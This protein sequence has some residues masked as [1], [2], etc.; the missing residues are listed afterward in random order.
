MTAQLLAELS[1]LA[2]G[3]TGSYLARVACVGSQHRE[4]ECSQR[5]HIGIIYRERRDSA[6]LTM[7]MIGRNDYSIREDGQQIGR[8][9][10]ASEQTPGVWLWHVQVNIP[11]PPIGSATTLDNAKQQF[12][13][14]W[15]AFK[16]KHGPERLA[17]AYA[18]MNLRHPNGRQ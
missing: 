6:M 15:L 8:I 18:A 1:Y 17:K 4:L 10:F 12:K 9:R 11:A 16:E 2:A 3:Q 14:A 5:H 13:A 7:G